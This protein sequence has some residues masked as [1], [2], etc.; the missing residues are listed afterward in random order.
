MCITET[1]YAV[2]RYIKFPSPTDIDSALSLFFAP[3]VCTFLPDPENISYS[4]GHKYLSTVAQ[5]GRDSQTSSNLRRKLELNKVGISKNSVPGVSGDEDSALKCQKTEMRE[6][7]RE[8][9][10]EEN[11][12]P[13][14]SLLRAQCCQ[15]RGRTYTLSGRSPIWRRPNFRISLSTHTCV[16]LL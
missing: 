5:E 10:V 15:L 12:N 1:V 11:F 13:P 2:S 6:G 16:W 3:N 14:F 8:P 7:G 4:A 9:Y